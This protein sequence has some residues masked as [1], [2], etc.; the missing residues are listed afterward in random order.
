M[1]GERALPLASRLRGQDQDAG[2]RDDPCQEGGVHRWKAA[3]ATSRK[4]RRLLPGN[5]RPK[6]VREHW[7]LGWLWPGAACLLSGPQRGRP[8]A[9]GG[10]VLRQLPTQTGP[11]PET[12]PLAFLT[13][14]GPRL[15]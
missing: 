3:G 13:H 12:R 6:A 5:G 14:K 7:S 9:D 4:E 11:S 8:D 1:G 15:T 10:Q 2:L